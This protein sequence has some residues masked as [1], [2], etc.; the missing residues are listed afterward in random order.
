M[1]LCG[2]CELAGPHLGEEHRVVYPHTVYALLVGVEEADFLAQDV[3]RAG[4]IPSVG[5]LV[6]PAR[7]RRHETRAVHSQPYQGTSQTADNWLHNQNSSNCYGTVECLA[8][9]EGSC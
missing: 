9:G 6:V 1:S 2:T 7:A 4:R 8:G 5:I 3:E